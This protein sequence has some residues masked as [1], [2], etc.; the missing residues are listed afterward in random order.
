MDKK[1]KS[2]SPVWYTEER[3]TE[4]GSGANTVPRGD[5]ITADR[6][7]QGFF[8]SILPQ[9]EENAMSTAELLRITGMSSQRV[10]RKLISEERATGAVIL[11]SD[12]GYFRPDSGEKGRAEAEAF[13]ATV[14][15]KGANTIRAVQSARAFLNRLPGQMDMGGT[16]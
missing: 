3:Q 8:E 6:R 16:F 9:G 4:K 14:T 12:K 1:E 5:F 10:L 13:I 2:R 11:S 15:A 7:A